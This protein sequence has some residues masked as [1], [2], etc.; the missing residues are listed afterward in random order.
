VGPRVG[1]DSVNKRKIFNYRELNLG[2]PAGSLSLYQLSYP[3]SY[4]KERKILNGGNLTLE[5][6]S[7]KLNVKWG[8]ALNKGT[9]NRGT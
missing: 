2:R 7:L 9:L 3:D 4:A 1:L 8:K 5:S 6:A